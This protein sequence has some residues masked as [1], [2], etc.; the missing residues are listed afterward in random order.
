MATDI[1][2]AQEK[3]PLKD[4]APESGSTGSEEFYTASQTKLVLLRLLRHRLA[5][6]GMVIL[7]LFYL[8]ATFAPFLSAYDPQAFLR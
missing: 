7:V 3:F 1:G 2:L 5:I 6:A 4:V 8:S